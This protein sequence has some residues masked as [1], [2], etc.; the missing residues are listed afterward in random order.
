MNSFWD[1]HM[2]ALFTMWI[3]VFIKVTQKST[4]AF[5]LFPCKISLYFPEIWV[6]S[7][8]VSLYQMY[9]YLYSLDVNVIHYMCG[10]LKG[11][12]RDQNMPPQNTPLWHK[13]SCAEGNWDTAG[14]GG[15]LCPPPFCLKSGHKLP[16]VKVSSPVPTPGREQLLIPRDSYHWRLPTWS[17]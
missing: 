14:A 5:A 1:H 9:I 12:E 15:T 6:H 2:A 8:D 10:G 16:F 11:V 3:N 4:V 13:D 17:A 7:W